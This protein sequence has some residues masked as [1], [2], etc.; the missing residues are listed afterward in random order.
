MGE[1]SLAI[2]KKGG[3]LSSVTRPAD[4]EKVAAAGVENP[5][6]FARPNGEVLAEIARMIDA[7]KITVEVAAVFPFADVGLAHQA[8]EAGHVRGKLVV[9]V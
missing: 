6:V 1:R 3:R 2:L 8:S 7:G 5:A 4:P 9:E